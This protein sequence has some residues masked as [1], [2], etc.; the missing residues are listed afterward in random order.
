[1]NLQPHL[2]RT[3][4]A[5]APAFFTLGSGG[6]QLQAAALTRGE[7][8]FTKSVQPILKEYC[9]TCHSTEKQKGDLDLERFQSLEQIKRDPSVWEHALEQIRDREM[10]PKDKPKPSAQQL[11][12]MKSACLLGPK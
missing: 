8:A 1:M 10:P 9:V 3:L 5:L 12:P 11:A 2:R 7:E 4:L 6:L